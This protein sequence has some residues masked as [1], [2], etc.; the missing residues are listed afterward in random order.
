MI[1]GVCVLMREQDHTTAL[2]MRALSMRQPYAEGKRDIQKCL[3]VSRLT[4]L[5]LHDA[6]AGLP[7]WE[8]ALSN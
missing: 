7:G 5:S 2:L 8:C 4:F 6:A 3:S 1:G